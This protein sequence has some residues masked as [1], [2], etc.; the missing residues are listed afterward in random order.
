MAR[1][2]EASKNILAKRKSLPAINRA[3][4]LGSENKVMLCLEGWFWFGQQEEERRWEDRTRLF[5]VGRGTKEVDD[6]KYIGHDE[7][8]MEELFRGAE[9]APRSDSI[10]INH[11]R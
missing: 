4:P 5:A 7:K 3:R 9:K 2:E 11:Q 1:A 8:T 10:V 6:V